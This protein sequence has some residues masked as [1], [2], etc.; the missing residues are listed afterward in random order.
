M[1]T[2]IAVHLSH[3]LRKWN[4]ND[5]G[6]NETSQD[7]FPIGA[8]GEGVHTNGTTTEIEFYERRIELSYLAVVSN[9]YRSCH[10]RIS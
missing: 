4:K 9:C 5:Y 10:Y 8:A 6:E 3:S 7:I 1:N 2:D